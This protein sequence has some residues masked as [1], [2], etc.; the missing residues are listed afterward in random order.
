MGQFWVPESAVGQNWTIFNRF[1]SSLDCRHD[2]GLSPPEEQENFIW[3]RFGPFWGI[4]PL[5]DPIITRS[6]NYG[7]CALIDLQF[8]RLVQLNDV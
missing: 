3:T 4:E 5:W 6:H 1:A 7:N 8:G 2:F